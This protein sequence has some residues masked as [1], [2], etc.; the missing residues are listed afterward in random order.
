VAAV[1]V[2]AA[3]RESGTAVARLSLA[4]AEA[5]EETGVVEDVPLDGLELI[6]IA[7]A[8]FIDQQ[9]MEKQRNKDKGKGKDAAVS[10]TKADS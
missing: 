5:R 10:D 3:I 6:T 4:L 8:A 9:K 7:K 1:A 2:N